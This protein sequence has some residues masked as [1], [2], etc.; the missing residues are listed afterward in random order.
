MYEIVNS[1]DYLPKVDD[2]GKGMDTRRQDFATLNSSIISS[3]E[4]TGTGVMAGAGT[5]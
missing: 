2:R 1:I 3:R 5:R 4:D